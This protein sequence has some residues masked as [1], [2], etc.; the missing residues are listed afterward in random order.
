M[1]IVIGPR[2]RL[3]QVA[4]QFAVIARA[5]VARVLEPEILGEWEL[6]NL[7]AVGRLCER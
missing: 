7:G 5:K 4:H 3:G 2:S 6:E 1:F